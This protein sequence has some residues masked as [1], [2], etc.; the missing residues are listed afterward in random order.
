MKMRRKDA[1][2]GHTPRSDE[3]TYFSDSSSDT[4]ELSADGSGASL[5]CQQTETVA[6]AELTEAEED[7]VDHCEGGDM[8]RQLDIQAAHDEANDSL[9]EQTSDLSTGRNVNIRLLSEAW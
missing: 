2:L 8:V 5:G 4:V 6:G 3:S 7:T 9:A 1:N